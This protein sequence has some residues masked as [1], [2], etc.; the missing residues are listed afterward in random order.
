V[1]T[2]RSES[3]ANHEMNAGAQTLNHRHAERAR[4][5]AM[6]ADRD[7]KRQTRQRELRSARRAKA[8]RLAQFGAVS[9]RVSIML[10]CAC[11]LVM[12]LC[13]CGGGDFDPCDDNPGGPECTHAHI[14][15]AP[16]SSASI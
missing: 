12:V 3:A 2:L 5:E 7:A 11:A 13:G 8:A 14:P 4:W 6:L 16:A 10:A 15:A 1:K 9:Y